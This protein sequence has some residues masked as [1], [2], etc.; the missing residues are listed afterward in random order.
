MTQ[1][2]LEG[3]I[4]VVTGA[5]S[6][7]G[8]ATA[9]ALARMGAHVV[10]VSRSPQKCAETAAQ[11]A[12]AGGSATPIAADLSSQRG[13]RSVAE[14]IRA[15]FPRVDVLVNNAGAIFGERRL[16]ED[17]IEMTWA[18]NHLSYFLLTHLLLDALKAAPT[19][20]IVNVSSDAHFAVRR[21]PF[22]DLN[23]ERQPYRAF[24]AYSLSKLANVMFTYALARRLEGTHITVNAL[25]PGAV[26][27]NFG[28]ELGGWWGWVF[29]VLVSRFALSPE[30]G[31]QTSIYLASAPEVAQQ[32]GLYFDRCKPKRSSLLSY[33]RDAQERLWAISAKQVQLAG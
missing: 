27:T 19:A 13:V 29:C 10:I 21:I 25:H 8:R 24:S 9:L 26:A 4:A 7:I 32:S 15:R 12:Q 3:R 28:R 18:L 1:R 30:Q 22:D 5:T 16:S 31:A 2:T 17:G 20:R 6:G 33:N 23:F 14:Q 11:I